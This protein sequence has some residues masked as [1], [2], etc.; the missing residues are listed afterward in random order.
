MRYQGGAEPFSQFYSDLRSKINQCAYGDLTDELLRDRIVAGIHG[1]S[2]RKQLLKTNNIT[3]A[4]AAQMC[5]INE[6]VETDLS[7]FKPLNSNT[8]TSTIDAVGYR[9]KAPYR[10]NVSSA[11]KC[12]KCGGEHASGILCPAKSQR[13]TNA[14]K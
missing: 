5:P 1:D 4:Q 12:Y 3:L 14:L 7:A 13:C 2:I 10:P 11:A 8:N 6:A 9:A